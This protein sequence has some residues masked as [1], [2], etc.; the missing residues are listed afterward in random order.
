MQSPLMTKSRTL[1]RTYRGNQATAAAQFQHDAA[2]LAASGYTPT[3]QTWAAGSYGAGAF[4][5]ALLL[6]FFVIGFVVFLYLVIVK[7]PGTLTVTYE[8]YANLSVGNE[9]VCPRCAETVKLAAVVCRFC[10][11]EFDMT[12]PIIVPADVAKSVPPIPII[13]PFALAREGRETLREQ[14]TRFNDM[15]LIKVARDCGMDPGGHTQHW[16]RSAIIEHIETEAMRQI[17]LETQ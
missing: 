4:I 17:R 13:D 9:K 6:C 7:P 3:S 5:V 8:A 14:L 1:V 2:Q 11:Y 15:E 16:H 10:N 12:A